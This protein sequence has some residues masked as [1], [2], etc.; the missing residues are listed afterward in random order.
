MTRPLKIIVLGIR[1]LPG[2]QGGVETHAEHLYTRLAA[3]GCQIEVVVRTPFV[4]PDVRRVGSIRLRRIWAPRR[5]GMEALVHSVLGVLYA[6]IARP[7]IL[8]VHAVGP[9]LI[10]PL[11][12]L[13]GLRVVMTHHGADYHRAKWGGFARWILRTGERWGVRHSNARIAISRVIVDLIRKLYD[14]DSVLI[15]NGVDAAPLQ[16]GESSLEPFHLQRGRYFLQVSRLVPEKNQHDLIAAFQQCRPRGWK[17]ALVGGL[18]GTAYASQL[19]A[20]AAGDPDIVLTDFKSGQALQEL[21]GNAGAFV[22]PSAHEGLPI[23]ILEA[24]SYGLPVIASDIP[25]NLEIGLPPD[26]YFEVG[27]VPRLAARLEEAA[28][29][30]HSDAERIEARRELLGRYNWD[31]IARSTLRLYEQTVVKRDE[32]RLER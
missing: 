2:V 22:L 8:H 4:P 27:N 11:A 10:T 7:D 17:L 20:A 19:Q 9:A 6:A 29:V 21:Y 12:R 18:D 30:A 26:C 24:L 25:A 16:V 23:A 15:P 31:E 5:P 14:K 3:L 13:C 1:G 32:V 28:L